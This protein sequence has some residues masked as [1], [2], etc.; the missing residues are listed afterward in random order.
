MRAFY[1]SLFHNR[2][3]N[4]AIALDPQLAKELPNDLALDLALERAYDLALSLVENPDIKQILNFSFALEFKSNLVVSPDFKQ[5]L[6]N[7]KQQLPDLAQG[8]KHLLTWWLT[9]GDDWVDRFRQIINKYR[10][11]NLSWDFNPYQQQLLHMY[12]VNNQ[13]LLQFLDSGV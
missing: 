4:L 7:L 3:L 8:K 1:F 10:Y 2:D 6:D 11:F 9:N 5:A 13:F 12:Y